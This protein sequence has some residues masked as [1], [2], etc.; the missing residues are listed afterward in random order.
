MCARLHIFV[1][2]K[3]HSEPTSGHVFF[4]IPV[5]DFLRDRR[6]I[7]GPIFVWVEVLEYENIDITMGS[8]GGELR[9][10]DDMLEAFLE[11]GGVSS[12]EL[13][14]ILS[15]YAREADVA[16]GGRDAHGGG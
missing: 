1:H 3:G 6:Q 5:T 7:E 4:I 16:V 8:L 12:A 9:R 15:G 10:A 13:W 14:V 11:D 2:E